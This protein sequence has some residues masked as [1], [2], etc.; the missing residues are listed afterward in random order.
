LR[1]LRLGRLLGRV[2]VHAGPIGGH[3]EAHRR[4]DLVE[5][6][7]PEGA[8]VLALLVLEQVVVVLPELPVAGAA[9]GR[10]GLL[11]SPSALPPSMNAKSR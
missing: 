8:L 10:R 11:R 9:G 2:A 7:A 3:V 6:L 4:R 1:R 5:D